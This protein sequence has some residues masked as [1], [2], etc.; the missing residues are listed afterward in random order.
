VKLYRPN[1]FRFVLLL[2]ILFKSISPGELLTAAFLLGL[3]LL[4]LLRRRRLTQWKMLLATYFVLLLLQASAPIAAGLET[5][6]R[7]VEAFFPIVPLVAVYWTLGFIPE[8]NPWDYDAFLGQLDHRL[9]GV[10]PNVWLDRFARHWV[11]EIM[12]LAYLAYYVLPFVLLADIYQ[13]GDRKAFD[14]CVTALLLSHYVAFVGYMV[15]PALGPRFASEQ[16]YTKELDGLLLTVPVRRLLDVLEGSKR[17]AF[18]S[19]HTSAVL[20]TVFYAAQFA[21]QLTMWFV[22]LSAL[23]VV[24]TVYLRYHYFVDVLAGTLLAVLCVAVAPLL[25]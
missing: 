11:T 5:I 3:I 6:P 15:V 9:L 13:S 20:I 17:D 1:P 10:K 22:P 24:S 4:V 19:G 16:Q 7:P 8:L 21:P 25:Q 2:M 12:Q 14:L 18:P 23:M